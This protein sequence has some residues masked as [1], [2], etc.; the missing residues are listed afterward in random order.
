MSSSLSEPTLFLNLVSWD[1]WLGLLTFLDEADLSEG[2]V[3]PEPAVELPV[4]WD[5][6]QLL[7]DECLEDAQ[8]SSGWSSWA[9]GV[10]VFPE[11]VVDR[12]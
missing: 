3:V 6:S 12:G 9:F 8:W 11:D 1:G 7:H 5:V 2:L 4:A 10:E